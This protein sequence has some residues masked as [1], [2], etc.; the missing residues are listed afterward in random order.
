MRNNT[1]IICIIS[2]TI[3]LFRYYNYSAMAIV[4]SQALLVFELSG[5]PVAFD[6]PD[7]KLPLAIAIDSCYVYV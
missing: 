6:C 5:G 7:Q 1:I 2:L 4:V 3:I